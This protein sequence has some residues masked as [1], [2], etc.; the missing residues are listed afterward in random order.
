MPGLRVDERVG[1]IYEREDV[2]LRA[3]V[4]KIRL[5]RCRRDVGLA[6]RL[7]GSCVKMIRYKM[8]DRY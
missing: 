4:R 7:I 8:M 3:R 5:F 2:R 1:D 6:V